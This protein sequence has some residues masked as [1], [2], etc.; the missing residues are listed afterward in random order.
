MGEI[1]DG[2]SDSNPGEFTLVND[3]AYY[4]YRYHITKEMSKEME[5]QLHDI[6]EKIYYM[7]LIKPLA[8]TKMTLPA[9][10]V[11]TK[12]VKETPQQPVSDNHC[13][14]ESKVAEGSTQSSIIGSWYMEFD[15][16]RQKKIKAIKKECDLKINHERINNLNELVEDFKNTLVVRKMDSI[17]R[18]FLYVSN[19]KDKSKNK[20][21]HLKCQSGIPINGFAYDTSTDSCLISAEEV[22]HLVDLPFSFSISI[23]SEW[24]EETIVP[25]SIIV[26]CLSIPEKENYNRF[27]EK[28]PKETHEIKF[29]QFKDCN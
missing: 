7:G 13:F 17:V 14:M 18:V 1:N 22:T 24:K 9:E 5:S 15:E 6:K 8:E 11:E 27:L 4:D 2:L 10:I 3:R 26:K 21:T 28:Y 25:S 19:L 29:I 20:I 16:V 23:G 12:I